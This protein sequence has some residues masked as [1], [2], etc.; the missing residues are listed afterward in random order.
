MYWVTLGKGPTALYYSY[1]MVENWPIYL[2][3][4]S[5]S[6]CFWP[7]FSVL[8]LWVTVGNSNKTDHTGVFMYQKHPYDTFCYC[9]WLLP[10]V[11]RRFRTIWDPQTNFEKN[12]KNKKSLFSWFLRFWR[13]FSSA[14]FQ[15]FLDRS[16]APDGLTQCYPVHLRTLTKLN[17]I[18]KHFRTL[19]C[20][21]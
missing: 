7:N 8:Y 21:G 18:S 9:C 13:I 16:Y 5:I 4:L 2:H 1:E 11:T 6:H 20:T 14:K 3:S 17:N 10:T 19:K 15:N 12:E